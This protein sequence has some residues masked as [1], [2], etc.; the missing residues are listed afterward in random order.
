MNTIYRPPTMEEVLAAYEEWANRIQ[1]MP[2]HSRELLHVAPD[3]LRAA[4]E[5]P[6]TKRSTSFIA[7]WLLRHHIGGF[8][9]ETN[10]R[11][12][13]LCGVCRKTVGRAL[14]D[15]RERGAAF[16][17]T[18]FTTPNQGDPFDVWARDWPELTDRA[19]QE[20]ARALAG[21][22]A[23]AAH[24]PASAFGCEVGAPSCSDRIEWHH[25][26]YKRED[27]TKVRPLCTK[28]HQEW[29]RN[30]TPTPYDGEV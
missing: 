29:H 8:V 9:P 28:H 23:R 19:K 12:A 20:R 6:A 13:S 11:I 25:D 22:K 27:W 21:T 26:S 5:D 18:V 4:A 30:N 16:R 24:G 17:C 15:L 3:M 1:Y 7:A 10:T 2:E 14:A